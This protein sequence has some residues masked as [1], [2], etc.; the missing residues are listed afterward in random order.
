VINST[1]L[2]DDAQITLNG[3]TL[4]FKVRRQGSTYIYDNSNASAPIFYQLDGWHESSHPYYWSKD[5]NIESELYDN[6]S[7]AV[8]IKTDRATGAAAK[9]FRNSTSYTSLGNAT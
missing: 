1:P 2:I 8:K 9:D 4:K 3:Q 7:A 6:A 5:F